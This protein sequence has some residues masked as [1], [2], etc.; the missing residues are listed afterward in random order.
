[1]QQLTTR[2]GYVRQVDGMRAVAALSV[3]FFHRDVLPIGWGG[4]WIFFVISGFVIT[5]G[6]I[7]K[8]F[9]LSVESYKQFTLSR[10]TRIWPLYFLYIALG[11]AS[12]RWTG[13]GCRAGTGR[14]F[15]S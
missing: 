7:S 5:R 8:R 12:R 15:A 3:V 10:I 9:S 4:V 13:R 11:L 6:L 1:M 2:S 14:S